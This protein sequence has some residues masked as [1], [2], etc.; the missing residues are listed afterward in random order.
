MWVGDLLQSKRLQSLTYLVVILLNIC[1]VETRILP[2]GLIEALSIVN[3]Y[4]LY[5]EGYP[6]QVSLCNEGGAAFW[7][8]RTE[9]S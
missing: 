8:P 1:L 9:T 6:C 7:V 5:A 4:K 3:N 2:T